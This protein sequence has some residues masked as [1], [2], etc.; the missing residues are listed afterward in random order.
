LTGK[1]FTNCKLTNVAY[2]FYEDSESYT[3]EGG[4]PYGLF[5]MERDV[6]RASTGWSHADALKLGITENFGITEEGKHDP[7]AVLPQTIDYSESIKAV[8]S[9]IT[10]MRYALA[11]FSSPNAE[12][13]I[14]KQVELNTV[15]DAGDLLISNENYNISEYIV[16]SAYDPRDQIPNPVYDPNNPGT[17]P[18]YIDNP[19]KDIRRVIKNPNYSPYKKIWNIDYYDGIYGLGDL[20][21]NSSLYSKIQSG[22]ITDVDPNIPEEFFNQDDMRYPMSPQNQTRLDSMNYIVPSD[23]FKYCADA[24]S[25][26]I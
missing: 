10:D 3:K 4:V 15:E 17:T 21:Q 12:G 25:T 26:N 9:S 14:R 22:S 18:E 13:Y 6:V 24:A 23:L 5:Y 2:A 1:G 20:I 8:R 11:N 16:N 7:D 19:N